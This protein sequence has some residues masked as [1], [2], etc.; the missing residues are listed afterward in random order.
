[1]SSLNVD[2]YLILLNIAMIIPLN[3][4]MNIAEYLR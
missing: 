1:M 4:R 2:N 3:I